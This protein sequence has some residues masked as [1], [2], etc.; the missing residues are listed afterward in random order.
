[1]QTLLVSIRPFFRVTMILCVFGIV[2][3]HFV[4]ADSLSGYMVMLIGMA[5]ATFGLYFV[6]TGE[7]EE[8]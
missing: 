2:L 1:M 8:E 3:N 5:M 6:G 4:N 7:V